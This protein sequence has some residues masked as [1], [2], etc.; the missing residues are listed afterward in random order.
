MEHSFD[1]LSV[2][3][4]NTFFGAHTPYT[5]LYMF[6]RVIEHTHM[7]RYRLH[8]N[9]QTR[10]RANSHACRDSVLA[11]GAAARVLSETGMH[12]M[13]RHMRNH[14]T[15]TWSPAEAQRY[16]QPLQLR[17]MNLVV[18]YYF[19]RCNRGAHACIC[20]FP[21]S[22][23]SLSNI[24]ANKFYSYLGE[25]RMRVLCSPCLEYDHTSSSVLT[26]GRLRLWV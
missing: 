25:S 26:N 9:S 11:S 17:K 14:S 15:V 21:C 19:F 12:N 6:A 2:C 4:E 13:E 22:C 18:Q 20:V 7:S 3:R 10:T 23:V 24:S 1:V 8:T 16:Q 5:Q